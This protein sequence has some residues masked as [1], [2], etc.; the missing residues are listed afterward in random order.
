MLFLFKFCIKVTYIADNDCWVVLFVDVSYIAKQY[1]TREARWFEIPQM[2]V[3]KGGPK[4]FTCT[5]EDFNSTVYNTKNMASLPLHYEAAMV[6]SGVGDALGFKNS[7]WKF[8]KVGND[9]LEELKSMGGIPA[10]NVKRN[11]T[12]NLAS[13]LYT[14]N[15][16]IF[17]FL[18]I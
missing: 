8:C 17:Y 11:I 18:A 10:L 3:V 1:L 12:L 13:L 14:N 7:S 15:K 6:L 5:C 16:E 4:A 9:I 2:T